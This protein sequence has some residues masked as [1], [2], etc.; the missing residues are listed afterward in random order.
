MTTE[1][2]TAAE[3][4]HIASARLAAIVSA[5]YL[6]S[7][8]AAVTFVRQPG[9]GTVAVDRR[10][11]IY[12]DPVVLERWSNAELAG[13]LLHE[14]N[15]VV[16]CHHRRHE[17]SGLDAVVWNAAA[18][19]E[20]NDDFIRAGI[21]LPAGALFPGAF[22]LPDHEIAEWYAQQLLDRAQMERSPKCGSGAG[23]VA[24][25]FELGDDSDLPGL[26]PVQLDRLRDLVAR[27]VV[28]AGAGVPGGLERWAHA[29]LQSDVSW[30]TV[31]R[32]AVRRALPKGLGHQ[33]HSWS[34][35]RRHAPTDAILP[36]LL[37]VPLHIA[38]IIDSSGSMDQQHLDLAVSD[39][40]VLR[41][42]PGVDRVTLV[43]C[44]TEAIE[45]AVP[46]TGASVALVGGGGTSL[47]AGLELVASLRRRPHLVVVITDGFTTWPTIAPSQLGSVLTLIPSE[48]PPGPAWMTTLRRPRDPAPASR[49]G[50]RPR[51]RGDC[52]ANLGL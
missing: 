20:I 9:L 50:S 49:V 12:I 33:R 34:R 37:G 21:E 17:L 24:G 48:G 16:R 6:A 40:A 42:V 30:P 8:L 18:D 35:P 45:I 2:P 5:P 38:V 29:R 28:E 41:A 13:A 10:L 52:R 36:S 22:N 1:T 3:M 19:L 39:I 25:D 46:R 15:H 26:G 43:S 32:G 23:G 27:A 31:L 51:N 4:A 47:G 7:V 14:V 11:R 44:D